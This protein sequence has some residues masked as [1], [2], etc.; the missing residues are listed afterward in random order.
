MYVHF[1][2]DSGKETL[3]WWNFF[4]ALPPIGAISRI[5]IGG[6][7]LPRYEVLNP[8]SVGLVISLDA[9]YNKDMKA[10]VFGKVIMW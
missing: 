10:L 6:R 4:Y 5:V 3:E 1:A 7:F 2:L 9:F 8:G